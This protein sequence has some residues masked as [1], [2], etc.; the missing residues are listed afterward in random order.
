VPLVD[1]SSV[2]SFGA[3]VSF[4]GREHV[5]PLVPAYLPTDD[6]DGGLRYSLSQLAQ[7]SHDLADL[8]MFVHD[9]AASDSRRHDISGGGSCPAGEDNLQRESASPS[10]HTCPCA[11]VGGAQ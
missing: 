9:A 7:P 6:A 1:G 4:G 2:V 11:R 8:P 3:R 5:Q 10:S